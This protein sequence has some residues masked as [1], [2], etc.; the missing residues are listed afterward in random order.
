MDFDSIH[1]RRGSHC[2]K[3]DLMERLYGVSPDTG[4]AMW[5]ADMD[6][7]SPEPVRAVVRR[8]ADEGFYGY[9]GDD[10]AYRESIRWWME[11]RHGWSLDPAHIFSTHGL[12]N[13]VGLCLNAYT[14]PATGS[15]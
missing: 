9:F 3:W 13:A 6:F 1:D 10:A 8:L 14:A 2:M 4:L 7:P 12:V 11:T 5:V 15:A